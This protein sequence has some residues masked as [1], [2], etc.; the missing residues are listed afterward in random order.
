M[1]FKQATGLV[2]LLTLAACWASNAVGAEEVRP[3]E[4][5][6]VFTV[7]NTNRTLGGYMEFT[8]ECPY[9]P[10]VY[11]TKTMRNEYDEQWE[12]AESSYH[13][14]WVQAYTVQGFS[15]LEDGNWH[16]IATNTMNYAG[17]DLYTAS[18]EG[19]GTCS[20]TGT[21]DVYGV[22]TYVTN[23]TYFVV[24]GYDILGYDYNEILNVSNNYWY[25]YEYYH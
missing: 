12:S 24:K 14:N 6:I 2:V 3:E 13:R 4:V 11:G 20:F 7:G 23:G 17:S 22:W 19:L 5:S 1:K 15:E 18:A 16:E 10:R 25:R 21:Q 9:K 8:N